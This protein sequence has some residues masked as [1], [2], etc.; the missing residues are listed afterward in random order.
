MRC[1]FVF[2]G[3]VLVTPGKLFFSC[4]LGL[5][6]FGSCAQKNLE[7]ENCLLR[8]TDVSITYNND[9]ALVSILLEKLH[10]RR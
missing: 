4:A 8:G 9:N 10:P 5:R 7:R 3:K 1:Q 2:H 6:F